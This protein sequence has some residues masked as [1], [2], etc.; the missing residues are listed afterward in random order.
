MNVDGEA[1]RITYGAL[2]TS[3]AVE[4]VR[5]ERRDDVILYGSGFEKRASSVEKT[6]LAAFQRRKRRAFAMPNARGA[7]R[8]TRDFSPP[9]ASL[10][11]RLKRSSI[12]IFGETR[13]ARLSRTLVRKIDKPTTTVV[14]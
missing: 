4:V 9:A 14:W 8:T 2:L 12:S 7:R 11:G 3:G 13:G 10:G 6:A 5:D 1:E